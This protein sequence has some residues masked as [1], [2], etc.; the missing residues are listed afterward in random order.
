[1]PHI[2]VFAMCHSFQLCLF[3][4]YVLIALHFHEMYNLDSVIFSMEIVVYMSSNIRKP[5]DPHENEVRQRLTE[6]IFR[7]TGGMKDQ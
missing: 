1:M 5:G 4:Y 2:Q 7:V 3:C 6:N